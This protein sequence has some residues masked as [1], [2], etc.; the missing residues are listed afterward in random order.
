MSERKISEAT[1]AAAANGEQQL[2]VNDGG[3]PKRVTVEQIRAYSQAYTRI[4]DLV[5]GEDNTDLDSSTTRHGLLP[6]LAGGTT[7]YLRADGTWQTPPGGSGGTGDV[8][9]PESATSG[10]VAVFADGTGKV[11]S[12][13]GTLGGAAFA[14]FGH[15][16]GDVADGGDLYG[17]LM[18]TTSAHGGII[19]QDDYRLSD[20]RAPT[21]HATTHWTGQSDALS[22][23]D[24]GAEP[25]GAVSNHDGLG[26][27]A[28]GGIVSD[29]DSRLSDDRYPT[30]HSLS[31][32]SGTDIITPSD[33][34]AAYN[35][36]L[37]GHTG[38]TTTAHGGIVADND[39]R[40]TDARTPTTHG[41]THTDGTDDIADMVGDS[42]SGGTHGL[43]PAPGTGDAAA[44]KYLKA[45]AT[46][47]VPSSTG[48]PYSG[49][50]GDVDLGEYA[51]AAGQIEL[52]VSPTGT[53]SAGTIYWDATEGLPA[54]MLNAS[55]TQSVGA[56]LYVRAVN[57]TGGPIADGTVVYI[58]GAQGNR[59]TIVAAQANAAATSQ[60]IGVAT[61]A[62]GNNNEGFVT[63]AGVVHGFNTSGY[64]AGN[65]LY[66]SATN[67]GQLTATAPS[68]PNYV[69]RV[70]T[71]LDSTN[72]GSILVH[73][74]PAL[75]ANTALGTDNLPPTQNAVLTFGNGRLPLNGF[76]DRTNSTLGMSGS[77]FQITTGTSY[78]FYSNGVKYTKNTTQS[79]AITNDL[80][81]HFVYF[82][83][84]GAIQVSTSSWDIDSDNV[85]A[86]IV[87]KDGSNYLIWEERHSY[88]RNR[89]WHKWAHL[90]IGARYY[91]GLA[92]TFTNTTMSLTQG[93]VYDEDIA[94][95]TGGT[96]TTCNLLY[97]NSG[98]TA[99]RVELA[100]STPYKANAGVI[101]YDNAGTLTDATANRYV[102]YY[103]YGTNDITNPIYSIV[104]Q[105]QHTNL[106]SAR[107]E[108]LPSILM[109]T[110]EWKLL[111]RVIYQNVG[112]TATYVESADYRT[113]SSLP[114]GSTTTINAGSVTY[115]PS[116][117]LA[118][119]NVQAAL[120][121]LEAEKAPAVT[122]STSDPSGTPVIGT[123]WAKVAV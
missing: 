65:T 51:L 75:A 21:A 42:G 32:I 2:P 94:N 58:S 119:T 91:T 46:W 34:G 17:H 99:M 20:A 113:A 16:N 52:D 103:I 1:P 55:V 117:N 112:G 59:P 12:D 33:I 109:G 79:V 106:S 49:A 105:A 118:A 102:C 28:H 36:D 85:P 74:N 41:S 71:A 70:A 40:L 3:L 45:D 61:E 26:T 31:H 11:L 68:S 15:D 88:R 24:I 80:T 27:A 78:D 92:G 62:I 48:V 35:S 97:R 29:G 60:I 100:S 87:Y 64:T 76:V 84:A 104:G 69:V 47:D 67:A 13:G 81:L 122:I 23:A 82:D 110:A 5:Q 121:E 107:A 44:G 98:L 83:S 96:K 37:T 66:L 115:V 101:R 6:K 114:G 108:S 53:P 38:E 22:A 10:N 50:T 18:E 39:S 90:T 9:G 8:T 19:G 86:A 54:V 7:K 111:Y 123:I 56:E 63:V 57:K 120:D 4:D 116:G 30:A 25:S 89:Q 72:N 93:T 73:T 77:N 43:V 95:D 14:D